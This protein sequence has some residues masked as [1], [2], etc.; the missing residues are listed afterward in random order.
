MRRFASGFLLGLLLTPFTGLIACSLGWLPVFTTSNPPR[1]ESFFPRRAFAAAVARRA[2]G[3]QNA[4][5]RQC[6]PATPGAATLQRL[7]R[8]LA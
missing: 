3:M 6:W 4:R 8:W 2:P 1:W 5:F 7:P